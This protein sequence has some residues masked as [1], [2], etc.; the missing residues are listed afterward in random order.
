MRWTRWAVAAAA[1]VVAVTAAGCTSGVG[2]ASGTGPGGN[3]PGGNGTHLIAG[4]VTPAA[5]PVPVAAPLTGGTGIDLVSAGSVPAL[6]TGWVEAEY[7][8]AG[9]A[10]SY[11]AMGPL[12]GDGRFHLA[13]SGT[14]S[15]KTRIVVRRPP[16]SK[17]NG[18]VV[19]EWLNVSGGL[20]AAPDYTYLAPE[21][22]RAG[23]AWVGVSAQYIGVEGGPVAVQTPVSNLGGAGK[24]L[25]HVD[26][27][28]YG[29]LHHPGDAFSYDIFTQVGRLL[30][31]PG[32]V[33][34][35]GTLHPHVLLAAGE[36]QS[37]IMLTTYVDGVQPL[38]HMYDGFL[39]HS[40]SGSAAPLGSPGTGIDITQGIGGPPTRIRTD[41]H[42]PVIM[43]ETESDVVGLLNYLPAS[44]PDTTRI[45]TWEVAGTAHVDLAQLGAVAK[46]FGC[47][48][49]V[50][51]GPDAFIVRSALAHLNTWVRGGAAP[52]HA[53]RFE[54][55]GG[56]Y[57]RNSDG[58]IEGGIRTPLVDV[59]V[60]VLSGQPGPGGSV[61]CLLAGSTTP[62]PVSRLAQL[63][64]S[65]SAYLAAYTKSTDAA[66]AAGFVLP[67]DRAAMLA[68]AQPDRIAG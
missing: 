56:K 26:P 36:S 54:I 49:P 11:R 17:F 7:S 40:R 60:D 47:S 33:D 10:T 67:A 34:P 64:P 53:P 41:L 29:S 14:A 39:I 30:R 24:G 6:P 16:A 22:I 44:Q 62:L 1:S 57:V 66:I 20:D 65:R 31:N 9:T 27:A 55:A 15:Y 28:R 63:Y 12:P 42:A 8:V 61:A 45:R 13:P 4:R 25:V 21:L 51:A 2:T 38:E 19:V 3:G 50:N 37:A 43:V 32:A 23:Y 18:T 48:T 5:G 52:P 68:L 46:L 58:I 35:L 59:P